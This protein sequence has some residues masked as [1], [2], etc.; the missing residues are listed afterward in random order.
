[1]VRLH[2]VF[3]I[4]TFITRSQW[5]A[6][7]KNLIFLLPLIIQL[8]CIV[9]IHCCSEIYSHYCNN[10]FFFGFGFINSYRRE[11]SFI[12]KIIRFRDHK[13]WRSENED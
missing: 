10:F 3:I 12:Y 8:T 4:S 11:R 7:I 6:Y 9:F 5:E 13:D 1:M 2:M